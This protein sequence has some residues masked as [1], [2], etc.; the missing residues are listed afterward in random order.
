MA[1]IPLNAILSITPDEYS[2]W[3]ICLNKATEDKEIYSFSTDETRLMEHISWKKYAGA[4][5]NFRSLGK[6]CLQFYRLD[7]DKKLNQ[8]L[9]L[10]AFENLGVKSFEDGHEIYDLRPIDRFDQFRERLIIFYQKVQGP[11]QAI[12]PMESIETIPVVR[13]TEDKYIKDNRPFPGFRNLSV[14]FAE[15][16]EI[17][18]LNVDNWRQIL[19]SAQCIYVISDKSNGKLYVGST[20]GYDGIWQRWNCYV[21]TN[22]HGN[23]KDLKILLATDAEYAVKN[24]QFSIIESFI[25]G[26]ISKRE[27]LARESYWKK[28]LMSREC[29][30]NWN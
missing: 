23:D 20:Y 21:E 3:T 22:G 8:W 7:K 11:K 14:S 19:S 16:K 27:I 26:D 15:L 9:F 1:N 5:R 10:G 17:I 30:Y 13:I 12:I 2:E 18:A 29:G 24:F 25:N 6:Y 28:V 4:K